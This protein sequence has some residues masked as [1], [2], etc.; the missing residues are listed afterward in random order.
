MRNGKHPASSLQIYSSLQ[1]QHTSNNS[2][3]IPNSMLK[4]FSSN[5]TIYPKMNNTDS[6]P[7]ILSLSSASHM[8]TLSSNNSTSS[9]TP[10]GNTPITQSR[11]VSH[12]SAHDAHHFV[13]VQEKTHR[14]LNGS[15]KKMWK[16]IKNHAAEH[17]RSVNAAYEA[18]YG[19][20]ARMSMLENPYRAQ[21]R[22][23]SVV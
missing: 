16:E 9:S 14:T 23:N 17:H 8:P 18:Q 20:G 15:I 13:S 3:S 2:T 1:L 4:S 5:Q 10:A 22:M 21:S 12:E 6:H 19:A 7:R 11:R